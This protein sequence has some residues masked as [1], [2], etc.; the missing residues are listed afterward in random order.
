MRD[1]HHGS[2]HGDGAHVL[3]DDPFGVSTLIYRFGDRVKVAILLFGDGPVTHSK[4]S[5]NPAMTVMATVTVRRFPAPG[6]EQNMIGA[7]GIARRAFF[8]PLAR[9]RKLPI[10]SDAWGSV[11][12]ETPRFG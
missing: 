2:A 5:R 6:G 11:S 12:R 8:R 9:W 3:L 7:H 10:E 1:D 4:R